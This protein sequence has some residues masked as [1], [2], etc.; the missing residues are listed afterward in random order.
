LEADVVAA[1]ASGGLGLRGVRA[2]GRDQRELPL[3]RRAH[4]LWPDLAE[5]LGRP[6]GYVQTG[7][8]ELSERPGDRSEFERMIERQRA[9]GVACDVVDQGALRELE[10]ELAPA[11]VAAVRCP[12]DGVADHTATTWAFATALQAAG[13]EIRQGAPVVELRQETSGP[14]AITA[15]GDAVGW[16]AG[17]L[18]AV[19]AA[20]VDL[21]APLGVELPVFAV[22]PQ[23]LVTVPVPAPL[24]SHLIGH[25]HR[26]LALKMLP[27]GEVMITGGWLGRDGAVDPEQVR[28]NLAEAV[29]VFPALGGVELATTD[30]SRPES[31]CADMVPVVDRLPGV[32]SAW[33]AAG[34]S[35]HGW[36]IAPAVAESL[37]AWMLQGERP[38][39]LAPFGLDRFGAT[40][41]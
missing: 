39:V 20:A 41:G 36:A 25:A 6:T 32:E 27:G 11:V 13:G 26:R 12:A 40:S 2:N 23:V 14:V 37:V 3:A 15:D 24:V 4:D 18:L 17:A 16:S 8:L 35:G 38:A 28:G 19:N 22:Y 21:V 31:I 9:V 33:V 5:R 1:G 30:A 10:P 34:W 7:H 29:A